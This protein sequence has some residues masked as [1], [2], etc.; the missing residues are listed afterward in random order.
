MH[1]LRQ[2]PIALLIAL[3]VTTCATGQDSIPWHYDLSQAPRLAEQQHRLVLLQFWSDNCATCQRLDATVFDQPELVR[4]IQTG[5][6]PVKINAQQQPKIASYYRVDRFP[7][8]IVV[9]PNGREV[10]RTVSP[11]KANSYIAM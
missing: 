9:L 2:A 7:T 4:V 1:F 6:I 11:P 5:C 3:A 10:F 8:D